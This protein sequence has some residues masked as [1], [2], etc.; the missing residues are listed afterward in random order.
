M[1]LLH[2]KMDLPKANK[3]LIISSGQ[4]SLNPRMV[5]EADALAN[6]GFDVT[7][8]YAYWNDW[9]TKFDKKLLATKKWSAICAGGDPRKNKS[10]YFFSRLIHKLGKIVNQRSGGKYFAGLAIARAGYFLTHEA[11]KHW[12]DLYIGHNLGAL[13]ATVKA[14]KANKSVCGFDAEDFH[15]FEVSDDKNNPDVILKTALENKYLAQV[16]YLTASSPLIADAYQQ[17]YPG[18]KPAVIRNVFPVNSNIQQPEI[19]RQGPVR[20]FWFSQTIGP[21]RGLETIM[22]ALKLLKGKPFELHLLGYSSAGMQNTL[23]DKELTGVYLHEPIAPDEIITFASQFDIGLAS[24]NNIPFNRNI[25]L[26]NKIFTYIQAGL[27]VVAS[28]TDA[29]LK[30]L[31]EYPGIGKVYQKNNPQALADT[32]LYYHLHREHL[33]KTRE[34]SLLLGRE[35][36]NWETESQVL[37]T[38]VE[39]ALKNH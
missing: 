17:L 21:N 14:A 22:A 3:I 25:C 4:P 15:R 10:I 34:Q 35:K 1:C 32:L 8:L 36:L 33:L 39:K 5:K 37:L 29:Q 12:A 20:L 26:T 27:A 6:E 19:N 23:A 13:A 30:M 11:K 24:E 28:D 2:Y 7:V 18:K 38:T 9:G 16:D 31:N